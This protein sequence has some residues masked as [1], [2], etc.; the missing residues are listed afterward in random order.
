MAA[1]FTDSWQTILGDRRIGFGYVT[2][3]GS[4][5]TVGLPL[6]VIDVAIPFAQ[7]LTNSTS[8]T[9]TWSGSTLTMSAAGESGRTEYV[10]YI[11]V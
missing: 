9:Y 3:D 11:G 7:F 1:T 5:T 4:D 6:G 10:L 2:H 8:T